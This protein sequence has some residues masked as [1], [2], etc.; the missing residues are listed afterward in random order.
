[1]GGGGLN[2]VQTVH[3]VS[4]WSALL[5]GM[6]LNGL[7]IWAVRRHTP[8]EMRVYSKVSF[9]SSDREITESLV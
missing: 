2:T 8:K 5:L 3:S 6:P 4:A 1:M 7:A 9:I